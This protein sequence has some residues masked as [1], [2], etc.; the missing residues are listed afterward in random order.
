MRAK[1]AGVTHDRIDPL[2]VFARDGWRCQLCSRKTP[3]AKRGTCADNAPE[4]DHI[5]PLSKGGPHSLTNVQCACRACN[6]AKG[7]RPLGQLLLIG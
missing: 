7:S 2:A 3:K 4:L 6:N 5:V 1:K